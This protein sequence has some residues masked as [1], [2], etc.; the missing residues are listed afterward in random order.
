M[1]SVTFE[2]WFSQGVSSEGARYEEARRQALKG[3][4]Q[5]LPLL[6]KEAR[7]AV[8][9]PP[10]VTAD[11]WTAW[12]STPDVCRR[13]A[14]IMKGNVGNPL[15]PKPMSGSWSPSSLGRAIAAL[16][17]PATPCILEILMKTREADDKQ[18]EAL[19]FALSQLRDRR[20][21]APLIALLS[22]APRASL[23]QQVAA[24]LGP[25]GDSTAARP[26]IA[27]VENASLS[28]ELKG[29][30][31]VSLGQLQAREAL[32]SLL[33]TFLAT[34]N[35][36]ILREQAVLAIGG[37]GD[38]AAS[39]P[40]AARL[41]KEESAELLKQMLAALDSVGD[42][43]ALSAVAAASNNNPDESVRERA[44]ETHAIITRRN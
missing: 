19:I 28:P 7:N 39:A 33:Q 24:A 11:A 4:S 30:A 18:Q 6:D 14:E 10:K 27:L 43:T 20:A 22:V 40:I 34:E 42:A 13:V 32:P 37:L 26:L 2:K 3:G 21:T 44:R 15:G 36:L 12:I 35:P 1:D 5:I 8:S 31:A 9:W 25:L 16:G 29:A 17:T 38:N 41:D 23:K